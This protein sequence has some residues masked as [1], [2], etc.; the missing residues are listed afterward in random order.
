MSKYISSDNLANFAAWDK[1]QDRRVP[2]SFDIEITARCNN[3]CRHC[4]INLPANDLIAK[5]KELTFEEISDI[6]DQAVELGAVWCLITGGEPLLRDDF[7][8]IYIKLKKKGLLVSLFTNA[9]LISEDDIALFKKYP[10]RD[11]EI[12]VYGIN[13]E[14]YEK[15]TRFPGSYNAFRRGLDLL[16]NAG[17]KV[18]LKAMAINSNVHELS[19]IAKFCREYST[20]NYRFDPVLHLRYD[21]NERRNNEIKSERLSPERIAQIEHEDLERSSYLQSHCEKLIIPKFK[22]YERDH[23]FNCGLGINS[24][25]VS[26]DGL[27]R[28]CGS[29][30][31]PD[32]IYDLRNGTLEDAWNNFVPEVRGMRSTNNSFNEKCLSC[33]I[34]NLCMNCRAHADLET[35][36]LDAIVPHFCEVAHAR[37]SALEKALRDEKS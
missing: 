12:S 25:T 34:T 6:A 32:C 8:E 5:S 27:F 16:L 3:N 13:Q 19:S 18:R 28:L 2:Y 35:G 17:F 15:V 1:L 14:T 23:L 21:R 26:Y 10:P 36:K 22:D 11:I 31:H 24:F 37:A 33:P 4:Y 30:W 9:C 20:E 7:S 29:L